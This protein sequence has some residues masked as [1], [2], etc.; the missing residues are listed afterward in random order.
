VVYE[1]TQLSLDRRVALKLFP[2]RVALAE[3]S[4][5]LHWPEHPHVTR[6]YAAGSCDHGYFVA[7]QLV[8]GTSL[9]TLQSAGRLDPS[10]ALEILGN[11]AIALDSAHRQGVAHGAVNARNVL[12]EDGGR[13]LLTDFGVG[14]ARADPASDRAAFAALVQQCL[15]GTAAAATTPSP[16]TAAAIVRSA[17]ERL[18]PAARRSRRIRRP[19]WPA[20]LGLGVGAVAAAAFV[21]VLTAGEGDRG[22]PPP[23]LR[24]VQVLGSGL[25]EPGVS[26]VGCDGRQAS[27]ASLPCS[28]VQTRLDGRPLT[29]PRG[30]TI[31][32]WTVR[33]ASGELALQVIRRRG[34]QFDAVARS[35]TFLVSGDGIEAVA[36]S[37]PIRAGDLVG[38]E[39]APG[40][41]IGVRR[42]VRGASTARWI[43][44]LRRGMQ[45]VDRGAAT[46]FDHEL[47]LRVEYEPGARWRPPGLVSG[48]DAALAPS[49]RRLGATDVEL[50]DGRVRAVAVVGTGRQI[51]IDVFAGERRLARLPVPDAD[52]GGRLVE[53]VTHERPIVI[54]SWRNG[55]G[56]AVDRDYAV[57]ASSITPRN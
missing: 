44:P 32:R 57:H 41:A 3:G 4:Q 50:R 23:L 5:R 12:V 53:L 38:L 14:P 27:G 43:G 16:D 11:V 34:R 42:D 31:R 8:R 25:A 37:L 30:G 26:S 47:Q 19:G 24:G 10:R 7:M 52:P 33:G 15:E 36:A 46:G 20:A 13:A 35:P 40:A 9:A 29:A 17:V 56:R 1:A 18:P 21:A 39:V 54:L 2:G 45:Q 48:P 49:G 22:T 6:L 28:V 55:D 51:A